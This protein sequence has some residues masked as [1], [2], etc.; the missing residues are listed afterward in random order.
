MLRAIIAGGETGSVFL[1]WV[2]YA[3]LFAAA[4]AVLLI[5]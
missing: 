3:T 1:Q 4:L 2:G 5:S